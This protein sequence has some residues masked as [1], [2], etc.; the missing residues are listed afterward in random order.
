MSFG[1]GKKNQG[2]RKKSRSTSRATRSAPNQHDQPK[3]SWSGNRQRSV[4]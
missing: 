1:A 2:G 4:S 3:K